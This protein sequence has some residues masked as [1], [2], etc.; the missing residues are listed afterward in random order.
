MMKYLVILLSDQSTSFCYCDAS[1]KEEGRLISIENLRNA[2]KYAYMEDL[3][4]V[5]GVV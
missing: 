3:L 4:Q 2:I 1:N 5:V